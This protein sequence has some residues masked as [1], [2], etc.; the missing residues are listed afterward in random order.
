MITQLDTKDVSILGRDKNGIILASNGDIIIKPD[1][2]TD[3]VSIEFSKVDSKL[4]I[5]TKTASIVTDSTNSEVY[6]VPYGERVEEILT[7][8]IETMLTHQHPPN[9]PATPDFHQKAQSFL[10]RI[11]DKWLSN[12]RFSHN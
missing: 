1:V 4:T 10:N 9:A 11:R 5:K 8:L 12:Q 7:W 2:L 3:N 6:T